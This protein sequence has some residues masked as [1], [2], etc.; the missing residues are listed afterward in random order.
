MDLAGIARRFRAD[1]L[2][3]LKGKLLLGF[4]D[5]TLR[6]TDDGLCK[7]SVHAAATILLLE[8]HNALAL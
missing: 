3:A 1:G 5:S 7:I 6:I 4:K 8:R 2:R